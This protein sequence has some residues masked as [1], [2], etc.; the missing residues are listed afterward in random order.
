MKQVVCGDQ[1]WLLWLSVMDA[2]KIKPSSLISSSPRAAEDSWW[3]GN[4]I[5]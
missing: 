5:L 1:S 2:K 4:R 3:L